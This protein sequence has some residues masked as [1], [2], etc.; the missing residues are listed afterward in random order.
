MCWCS[1]SVHWCV[2][3]GGGSVHWCVGVGGGSV[4]WC[5]GVVSVFTGVLV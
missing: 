4:H 5:V 2:G 3:V 1:G